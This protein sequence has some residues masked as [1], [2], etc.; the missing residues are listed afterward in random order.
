MTS[1]A[2]HKSL[3]IQAKNLKL[4]SEQATHDKTGYLDP[5]LFID[6]PIIRDTLQS[7]VF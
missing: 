1:T 2:H 6:T 4:L 3:Q 7:V 5:E